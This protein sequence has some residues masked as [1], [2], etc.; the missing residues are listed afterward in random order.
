MPVH[1]LPGFLLSERAAGSVF[2][3]SSLYS[4]CAEFLISSFLLCQA[5]KLGFMRG[6]LD[7]YLLIQSQKVYGHHRICY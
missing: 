3:F 5:R 4:L 6:F 2:C 7:Y 1:E